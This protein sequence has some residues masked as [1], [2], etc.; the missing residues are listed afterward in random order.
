M[1]YGAR[2]QEVD[3]HGYVE[4]GRAMITAALASPETALTGDEPQDVNARTVR[5]ICKGMNVHAARYLDS[6]KSPASYFGEAAELST[7]VLLARLLIT[8]HEA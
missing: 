8:E 5:A 2:I 3:E 1:I 6:D 4:M 7:P